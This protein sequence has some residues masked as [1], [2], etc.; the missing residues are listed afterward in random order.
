M[1]GLRMNNRQ[2]PAEV[3]DIED[4]DIKRQ[5]AAWVGAFTVDQTKDCW[6]GRQPRIARWNG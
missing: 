1:S 2:H 3:D 4:R 5:M 6:R